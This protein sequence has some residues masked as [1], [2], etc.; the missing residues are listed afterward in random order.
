MRKIHKYTMFTS[1]RGQYEKIFLENNIIRYSND[2]HFELQYNNE[3]NKSCNPLEIYHPDDIR[4]AWTNPN[5]MFLYV[6]GEY[7]GN[8]DFSFDY[9]ASDYNDTDGERWKK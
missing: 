5:P 1:G 2:L 8:P 6:D 9:V 7:I 4:S 3:K